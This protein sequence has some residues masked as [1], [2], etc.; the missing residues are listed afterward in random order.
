MDKK[1]PFLN[2]RDYI[3][4]EYDATEVG[5]WLLTFWSFCLQGIPLF[6]F[7]LEVGENR[8]LKMLVTV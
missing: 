7:K 2:L 5:G 4:L 8:L 6:M 1:S 3:N